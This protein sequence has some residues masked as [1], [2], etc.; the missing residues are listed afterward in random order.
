[1]SFQSVPVLASTFGTIHCELS[2]KEQGTKRTF[3]DQ[4]FISYHS[5][6]QKSFS[7]FPK[8][9]DQMYW[10]SLCKEKWNE[11]EMYGKLSIKYEVVEN[12]LNNSQ[13]ENKYVR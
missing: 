13:I 1:M 7:I 9:A 10:S 2:D 5:F 6:G 3:D 8:E 12:G 11:A 4:T